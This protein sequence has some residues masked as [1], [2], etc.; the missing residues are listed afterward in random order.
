M[1]SR[2]TVHRD[3][4]LK[5]KNI[6][7]LWRSC[8]QFRT[9]GLWACPPSPYTAKHVLNISKV[10]SKINIVICEETFV[11]FS[12]CMQSTSKEELTKINIIAASIMHRLCLLILLFRPHLPRAHPK[13]FHSYGDVTQWKAANFGSLI[14]AFSLSAGKMFYD[15][16]PC[17]TSKLKQH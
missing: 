12:I 15:A 14:S 6:Y 11:M 1:L 4:N 3:V 9:R 17:T 7:F 8:C 16:T 10:K 5:N 13:I 2:S